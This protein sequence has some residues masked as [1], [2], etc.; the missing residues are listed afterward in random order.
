M[1]KGDTIDYLAKL[2]NLDL[3]E[4][5][6]QLFNKQFDSI[7]HFIEKLNELNTKTTEPVDHVTGLEN[8]FRDDVLKKGNLI[9]QNKVLSS[10]R[11]TLDGYFI[12]PLILKGKTL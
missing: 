5:E 9:A 1:L 2:A 4:H 12:V 7:L 6:S 3:S 8:V 10:A 11:K